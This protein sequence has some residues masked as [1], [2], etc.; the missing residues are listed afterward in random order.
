MGETVGVIENA[1]LFGIEVETKGTGAIV[2]EQIG[3][4]GIVLLSHVSPHPP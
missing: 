3:L 4:S 1:A 2:A